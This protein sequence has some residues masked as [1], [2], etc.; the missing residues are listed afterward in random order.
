MEWFLV[1]YIFVG[2]WSKNDSV[3]ITTVPMMS[4]PACRIAGDK[5]HTLVEGTTKE[6]RY[7]C[8]RNQ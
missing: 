2:S 3:T 1:I 8:V 7:V 4:E 5:L 6:V